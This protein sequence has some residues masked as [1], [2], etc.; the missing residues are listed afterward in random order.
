[1]TMK[2]RGDVG[3]QARPSLR[4][5]GP[6]LSAGERRLPHCLWAALL[7]R[8]VRTGHL[9]FR[10]LKRSR[11]PFKMSQEIGCLFPNYGEKVRGSK[12]FWIWSEEQVNRYATRSQL[13]PPRLSLPL[14][15]GTG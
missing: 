10:A 15:R 6:H 8:W 2:G 4:L 5:S 13:H 11:F 12:A 3:G 7:S 9:L 14:P 1:M